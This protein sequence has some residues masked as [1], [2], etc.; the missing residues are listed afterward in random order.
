[1]TSQLTHTQ[2]RVLRAIHQLTERDPIPP[3]YRIIARQTGLSVAGAFNAVGRLVELGFVRSCYPNIALLPC[4]TCLGALAFDM[5]P[6]R[7]IPVHC[8][9]CCYP[10][11]V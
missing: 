8:I 5:M 9:D 4:P 11:A 2:Q 3:T 1:M 6:G 10:V 7:E